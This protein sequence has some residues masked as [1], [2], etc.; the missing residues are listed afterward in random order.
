M[1]MIGKVLKAN[2]TGRRIFTGWWVLAVGAL[3]NTLVSHL[4]KR[5]GLSG[6]DRVFG[7]FFGVLRGILIILVFVVVGGMTPLPE[8]DWWQSSVLLEWFEST[9]I[10]IQ[11]YIPQDLGISYQPV[12]Q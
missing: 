10:V 1:N 3:I 4:V 8:A 5:T 2:Q 12:S 11:D 9:A 7:V 6:A